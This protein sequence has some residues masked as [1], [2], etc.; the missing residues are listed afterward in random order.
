[1]TRFLPWL[2]TAFAAFLIATV[3]AYQALLR[4]LLP[5]VCR[6]QP[7]CSEYFILA[8]QQHGPVRGAC[9]GVWRICRCNPFHQGGYDPP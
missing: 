3:R 5:S 8:V 7:S 4:P 6:F 2:R 9:K 1:M